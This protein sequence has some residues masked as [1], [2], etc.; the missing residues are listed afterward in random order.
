MWTTLLVYGFLS[1]HNRKWNILVFSACMY[2]EWCFLLPYFSMAVPPI[3]S[4][5][6][7]DNLPRRLLCIYALISTAIWAAVSALCFHRVIWV[8]IGQVLCKHFMV[9]T[10]LFTAFDISSSS[11]A[12]VFTIAGVTMSREGVFSLVI[13]P[14]VK[15]VYS[16]HDSD[17]ESLGYWLY[18]KYYGTQ[19][20]G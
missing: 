11:P 7:I 16:S 12:S 6:V 1:K 19:E 4:A 13:F 14:L 20:S 17:W 5:L 10:W 18:S 8:L 2:A 3:I 15:S 9:S